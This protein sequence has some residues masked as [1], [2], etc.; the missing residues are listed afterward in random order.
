MDRSDFTEKKM[1]DGLLLLVI[2]A[3]LSF[4]SSSFVAPSG[5]GSLKASGRLCLGAVMEM[6]GAVS[7]VEEETVLGLSRKSLII[8]HSSASPL[9]RLGTTASSISSSPRRMPSFAFFCTTS[10]VRSPGRS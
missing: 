4:S 6:G 1:G 8:Y 2:H 5:N 3:N 9:A 10:S 7:V